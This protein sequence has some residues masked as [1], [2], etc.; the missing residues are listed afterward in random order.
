MSLGRVPVGALED[1]GL[2]LDPATVRLGDIFARGRENVENQAAARAEKL[3]YV[4]Q[5]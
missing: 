2:T 3:T 4:R 5:G 1:L